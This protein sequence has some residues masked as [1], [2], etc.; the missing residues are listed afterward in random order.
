M[1]KAAADMNT[2]AVEVVETEVPLEEVWSLNHSRLTCRLIVL[3]SAYQDECDILPG[4]EFE[5]STGRLKPDVA[6]AHKQERSWEED[7]I[8][9]P[10]PPITAIEILSPTQALDL[11]IA[12]IRKA[13]FPAGVKSAWL[14]VPAVKTIYVFL[15]EEAPRI[16]ATGTLHDPASGIQLQIEEIFK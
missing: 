4:L 7:I 13:Y 5:L 15:P 14:V 8:R 16:V 1:K 9:Y 6:I 2:Q 3:L 12:K 10:H 11:L